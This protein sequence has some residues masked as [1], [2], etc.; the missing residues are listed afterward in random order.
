HSSALSLSYGRD[1]KG[2]WHLESNDYKLVRTSGRA[3]PLDAPD[4]FYRISDQSRARFQNADFLNDF[5]LQLEAALNGL[6]YLGPLREY[7]RRIYTWS[8]ETPESVGQKGELAIPAI[9]AARAQ[10]RQLNRGPRRH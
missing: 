7:P 5:A 8:G 6:Y 1:E 3:W 9:L 2:K 4:K 10:Q